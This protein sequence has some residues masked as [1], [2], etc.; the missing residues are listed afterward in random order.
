MSKVSKKE[1]RRRTAYHE[2]GHAIAI[3]SLGR[4]FRIATIEPE[5]DS[6]GYVSNHHAYRFI[7]PDIASYTWSA[8]ERRAVKQQVFVSLAGI[9]A[10]RI[11]LGRYPRRRRDTTDYELIASILES[12]NAGYLDEVD[13]AYI[14]YMELVTKNSIEGNWRFVKIVAQELLE[15]GTLKYSEVKLLVPAKISLGEQPKHLLRRQKLLEYGPPE[16]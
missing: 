13:D 14:A 16:V 9:A 3:L 8:R 7:D 10:V 4:S 6:L 5:D 12:F 11:L 2:A 15:K 1:Q